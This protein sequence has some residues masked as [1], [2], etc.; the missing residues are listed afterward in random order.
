MIFIQILIIGAIAT[1]IF[2]YIKKCTS[3][4]NSKNVD[5]IPSIQAKAIKIASVEN[6]MQNEEKDNPNTKNDVQ[7]IIRRN[8]F[9]KMKHCPY[10]EGENV[11]YD[12]P[13]C[14]ANVAHQAWHSGDR[15]AT[16]GG[17]SFYT[18]RERL[19]QLLDISESIDKV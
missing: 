2:I 14:L 18:L 3:D 10:S 1:V 19:G 16:L 4:G 8:S 9:I 12:C 5:S 15:L 17:G 13:C 7:R 6:K 11:I